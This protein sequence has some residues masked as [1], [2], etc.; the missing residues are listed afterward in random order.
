M[1]RPKK[2]ALE[3]TGQARLLPGPKL[4][5]MERDVLD[6]VRTAVVAAGC[7]CMRNNVGAQKVG[8]RFIRYGLGKGSADLI[9]IVPPYGRF[10][11]LE[12]KRPKGSVVTP[13]QATWAEAVRRYGGVT[14]VV[15]NV[16]EAMLLVAEARR[17]P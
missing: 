1:G 17:L 10:L 13:E 2:P 9:C 16:S 5:E 7:I 6:Q 14:G 15:K 4:V 11:G 12:I 8:K 3:F